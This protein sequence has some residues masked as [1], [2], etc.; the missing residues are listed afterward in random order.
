MTTNLLLPDTLWYRVTKRDPRAVSLYSRHYSA[1]PKRTNAERRAFGIVAPGESLTL[2]T[3]DASALFV[4]LRSIRNDGQTG[5]NCAVFRNEGPHLSSALI[6]E[7]EAIAWQ[8]WPGARLF[9]FVNPHKIKSTNPGYCFK[10]ARWTVAGI[11]K[12]RGLIVLEKFPLS[13]P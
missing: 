2:I 4:W 5:V 9:T 10:Q 8:R 13:V 1:N 3:P 12:K 11:T 6:L 7:A